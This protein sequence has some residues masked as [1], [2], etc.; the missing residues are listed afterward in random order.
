MGSGQ[1]RKLGVCSAFALVIVGS[2]LSA[3]AR[4]VPVY[5][6]VPAARL[7]SVSFSAYTSDATLVGWYLQAA[8]PLAVVVQARGTTSSSSQGG[9]VPLS[10]QP[11]AETTLD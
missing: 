8:K 11:L 6:A 10:L 9:A 2:S 7:Q 4:E 3:A 1:F 5:R